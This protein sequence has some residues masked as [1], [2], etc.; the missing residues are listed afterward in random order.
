MNHVNAWL[1][2]IFVP[3]AALVL[4]AA[5][6]WLGPK[7]FRPSFVIS[8]M[9]VV[10]TSAGLVV[11]GLFF[12]E[13]GGPSTANV[14]LVRRIGTVLLPAF[15]ALPSA[16]SYLTSSFLRRMGVSLLRA[17]IAGGAAGLA[18]GV[19]TPLGVLVAGCGL[20]GACL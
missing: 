10:F 17:R 2:L 5:A 9:A 13:I 14:A 15:F 1:I 18:S 6:A 12:S 19:M 7:W 4:A 16:F 8:A 20:A 11:Y 3:I